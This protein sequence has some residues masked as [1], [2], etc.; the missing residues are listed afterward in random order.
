MQFVRRIAVRMG[1]T[2][3]IALM[4]MLAASLPHALF[5]QSEDP[6][7]A[8][9]AYPGHPPSDA[10]EG[11]IGSAKVRLFGTLLLNTAVSYGSIFGQDVP[12]WTLPSAGT[13]TY[14]DGTT[15]TSGD[16]HDLIFT[17]RQSI[18]GLA[19]TQGQATSGG[20][21][22]SGLLEMDF[23][24][25][26]PVD[27]T[28]PINRV[29]NQPRLRKAYGQLTH[30]SFKVLFG[31]DTAIFAPIDPISL[32]HVGLPLGATAGNLWAW[33]PQVR[34]EYT[35]KISG[36]GLLLQGGI[37]KPTF[38]DS[39]LE[40]TPTASTSLDIN[41][42]G[43]GERTTQP[44]YEGRVAVMPEFGGHKA[45][46]AIAGH[47]GKERVGVASD[48][49][50]TGVAFDGQVPVGS[51]VV[52]RGEA[53][54]GSN[55]IPFQGGI[56]QG[57]AV[58]AGATPTAPP[59]VIQPIHTKGGWAEFTVMPMANGRDAVYVGAG[60]DKPRVS[61]LLPGSTRTQNMFIWASYFH[62]FTDAVTV[63]AEWSKWDFQTVTFVKN[64]PGPLNPT[65]TA[66]VLNISLAY[67]F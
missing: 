49:K 20:W 45:T 39:R 67:Q 29:L 25:T 53:Y 42:S 1:A 12:L 64:A 19:V 66:N 33:L 5:A 57:V 21:V 54:T 22:A 18:I 55:L 34:V 26:R 8:K 10:V 3:Q 35:Q 52:V 4:T 13:V 40:T 60:E 23:F 24:G 47:Y 63:A 30:N 43:L 11:T 17:T 27:G 6:Q 62:K 65:A 32:S 44:F 14:P 48:V 7:G 46:L 2:A 50:S 37:L 56:D 28:V 31:Q 36:A 61:D 15:G 16:S 41:T 38:G 59:L 9:P 58:L 51:Y